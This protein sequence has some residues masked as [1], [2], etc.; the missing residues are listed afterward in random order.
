[1][2]CGLGFFTQERSAAD[3]YNLAC[4][5][6]RSYRAGQATQAVAVLQVVPRLA[7]LKMSTEHQAQ[8]QQSFNFKSGVVYL[9]AVCVCA[10]AVQTFTSAINAAFAA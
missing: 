8:L 1:M 10:C 2:P 7:L 6:R 5:E 3:A 4:L 9:Q